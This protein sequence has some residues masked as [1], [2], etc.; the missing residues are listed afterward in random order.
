M[1]SLTDNPGQ[2]CNRIQNVNESYAFS[3]PK[4]DSL[5]YIVIILTV[6]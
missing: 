2:Q 3:L 6:Q 4:P 1:L 5:N